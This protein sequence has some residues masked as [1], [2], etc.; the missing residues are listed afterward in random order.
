MAQ[1]PRL[2]ERGPW[3]VERC[4]C[5]AIN[6]RYG[7]LSMHL[8]QGELHALGLALRDTEEQ[9]KSQSILCLVRNTQ[10]VA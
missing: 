7:P 5:G 9:L 6:L 1:H 2:A 10:G 8:S 3:V 4:S